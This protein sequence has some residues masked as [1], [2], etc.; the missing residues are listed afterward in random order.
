MNRS[1]PMLPVPE[2][3]DSNLNHS[4]KVRNFYCTIFFVP[5]FT[6]ISILFSL[7]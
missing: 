4:F 3:V 2:I 6:I 5:N 1:Y 7:T